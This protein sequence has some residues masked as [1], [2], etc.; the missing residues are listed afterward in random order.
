MGDSCH[1]IHG[2]VRRMRRLQMARQFP[3]PIGYYHEPRNAFPLLS[4]LITGLISKPRK[5]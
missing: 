3:A 5:Q 4:S 1:L 2:G